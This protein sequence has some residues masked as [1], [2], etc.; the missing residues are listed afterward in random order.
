MKP[1]SPQSKKDFTNNRPRRQLNYNIVSR[2]G[3][4][5]RKEGYTMFNDF[6]D[7]ADRITLDC[8]KMKALLWLFAEQYTT[9]RA[10]ATLEAIRANPEAFAV[11]F[12]LI[13]DKAAEI[14]KAACEIAAI[15]YQKETA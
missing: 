10:D 11:L 6:R 13:E 1:Y 9:G 3:Q 7:T 5:K 14:Q 15:A 12:S 8:E 2:P 4:E